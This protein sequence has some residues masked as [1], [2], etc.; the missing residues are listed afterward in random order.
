MEGESE[1][2]SG[3]ADGSTYR[4]GHHGNGLVRHMSLP[5]SACGPSSPG[6]E[7][8]SLAVPMRTRAK[9]GCATHPR[10]IAE[11]VRRTKISER[12]KRLQDLVPEMDKQTNTS[13]MLDE[14]VEYV[15]SL[16][17]Q[18]QELTETVTQL[19]A[20]AAKRNNNPSFNTNLELGQAMEAS[21]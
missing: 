7:D 21:G 18:V 20:A 9:R 15:K 11:R 19:Q 5:S 13:D 8:D 10:S 3:S 2:S 17:R 12:M 6:V 14:T 16:Q 4:N 1:T